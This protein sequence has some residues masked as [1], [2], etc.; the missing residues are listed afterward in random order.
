M[1]VGNQLFVTIEEKRDLDFRIKDM[2]IIRRFMTSTKVCCMVQTVYETFMLVWFY[3]LD[4]Q[5]RIWKKK[6]K[7]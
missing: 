4:N 6:K 7:R 1:T 5:E 3:Q 2:N